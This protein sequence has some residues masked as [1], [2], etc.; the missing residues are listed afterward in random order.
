MVVRR[1]STL[2]TGGSKHVTLSVICKHS[3][4]WEEVVLTVSKYLLEMTDEDIGIR[5]RLMIV[6]IVRSLCKQRI[7][8]LYKAYFK[9][10]SIFSQSAEYFPECS[11]SVQGWAHYSI[12]SCAVLSNGPGPGINFLCWKFGQARPSIREMWQ[13]LGFLFQSRSVLSVIMKSGSQADN[14]RARTTPSSALL[15]FSSLLAV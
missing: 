15:T 13:S 11:A 12:S 10:S 4:G 1:N 5:W 2:Y 6:R 3:E 14:D 8:I 7:V 9:I